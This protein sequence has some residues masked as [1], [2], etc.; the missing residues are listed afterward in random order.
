VQ[1]KADHVNYGDQLT[2]GISD[3]A[4]QHNVWLVHNNTWRPWTCSKSCADARLL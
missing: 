3:Y 1:Q 4:L 2:S